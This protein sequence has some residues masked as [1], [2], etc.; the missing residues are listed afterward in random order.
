MGD[1]V[2]T[3]NTA[4]G[5]RNRRLRMQGYQLDENPLALAAVILFLLLAGYAFVD[6]LITPAEGYISAPPY[7]LFAAV[8]IGSALL[9]GFL[10]LKGRVPRVEAMGVAVLLGVAA[11]F[12]MYPGFLRISYLSGDGVFALRT[13]VLA[14]NTLLQPQDKSLPVF[15]GPLDTQY[16]AD[17]M[18]GDQWKI[19]VRQGLLGVWSYRIKPLR[20]EIEDFTMRKAMMQGLTQ[21]AKPDK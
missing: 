14:A 7:G 18:V 17:H 15:R 3:G 1:A 20:D 10:L 2:T 5:G 12:A 21:G 13:Y 4:A 6:G 11:G 19:Y 16:W 8:G 9:A